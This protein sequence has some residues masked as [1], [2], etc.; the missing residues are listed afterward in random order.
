MAILYS[1]AMRICGTRPLTLYTTQLGSSVIL[2]RRAVTI[3][4]LDNTQLR[5]A[6]PDQLLPKPLFVTSRWMDAVALA[7]SNYVQSNTQLWE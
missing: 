2:S 6:E 4:D 7:Y 1:F 5:I 3:T